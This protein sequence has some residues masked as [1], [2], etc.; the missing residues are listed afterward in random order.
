MAISYLVFNRQVLN[1]SVEI[2]FHTYRHDTCKEKDEALVAHL[3]PVSY[4]FSP[5]SASKSTRYDQAS[6]SFTL[7]TVTSIYIVNTVGWLIHMSTC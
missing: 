3:K 7:F 5:P 1:A 4:G 2:F 6:V